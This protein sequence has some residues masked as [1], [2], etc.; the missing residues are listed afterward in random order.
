M[1]TR[2][3]RPRSM[4]APSTCAPSTIWNIAA[5]ARIADREAQHAG[6]GRVASMK[7]DTSRLGTVTISS[8]AIAMEPMPSPK[9][10]Q[11][12]RHAGCI[13]GPVRG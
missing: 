9:A 10:L 2:V 13:A 11:P 3:R 1:G 5:T 6:V 4:P 12:A 8:A 7:A